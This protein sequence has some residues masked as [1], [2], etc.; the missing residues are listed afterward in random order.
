MGRAGRPA[1]PGRQPPARPAGR[2]TENPYRADDDRAGPPSREPDTG[3]RG[4]RRAANSDAALRAE[5]EVYP[6][7]DAYPGT[8]GQPGTDDYPGTEGQPG[9]DD[10]PGTEGQPGTEGRPSRRRHAGEQPYAGEP[11][12][13][14]QPRPERDGYPAHHQQPGAGAP[15]IA[16]S[17]RIGRR[18]RAAAARLRKSRRRVV[19]WCVAGIV[20]CVVAAG[21]VVL[22]THHAPVKASYVTSL[23]AGEYKAAPD[24]CSSVSAA[25]LGQYLPG[26]GRTKSDQMSGGAESQC[27]FTIDKKPNLLVLEVTSQQYQPLAAASGNG[28]GSANAQDNFALAQQGLTN[29][30]KHSPL[31]AAAVSPVAKLGQKAIVAVQS[32]HVSG[33]ITTD[34][35]TVLVRQRNVVVTVSLSGQ[36]SGHGFGPVAV[37]T[38][39]A[40]A[41]AAARDVLARLSSIPTA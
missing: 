26:P 34:L 37:Q 31:S 13:G 7:T 20:A 10:Y 22:V 15:P 12:A 39:E 8:E 38:L 2:Q 1:A 27:S 18:G 35:V 5:Q 40:G 6:G 4:R 28:S 25:T 23:Q 19:R 32:E 41:T 14:E 9:T 16:P 11:Y 3:Y 33:G 30:V 36:E 21:I 17:R 24:A 29:P